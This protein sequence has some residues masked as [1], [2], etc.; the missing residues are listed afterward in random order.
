MDDVLSGD[1]FKISIPEEG[2]AMTFSLSGVRCPRRSEAYGEE[3]FA[4]MRM[5][6]MQRDV[7]V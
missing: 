6:I 3:A 4:F 2:Y 7:E 1:T 5:N